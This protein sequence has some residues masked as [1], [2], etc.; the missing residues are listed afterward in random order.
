MT[1][2]LVCRMV[3]NGQAY[4]DRVAAHYENQRWEKESRSLKRK[5]ATLGF[6]LVPVK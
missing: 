3:T 5:T 2:C 4:V 6:K 1:S